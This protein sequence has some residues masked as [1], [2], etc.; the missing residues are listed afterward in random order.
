MTPKPNFTP[1]AQQ[2]IS[3]AKRVAKKFQ[4]NLISVE[5][6]FYAIVNL[7]AGILNE[8]LFI[9][10]I[11]PEELKLEIEKSL[12]PNTTDQYPQDEDE[13][14]YD[15]HFHLILKVSVSISSKL[16]HEYVGIEHILLSLL[17]YEYS[18]IPD[19]FMKFNASED[20]IISEVREYLHIS[21]D[22]AKPQIPKIKFTTKTPIQKKDSKCPNLEKFASNLMELCK[23]KKIDEVIGKQREIE[24]VCEILCRRT[25]NNPV[26]LGDPGVGKTAI[27]EGLSMKIHNGDCPDFLIGK[28][29]YSLDL[30]SLI[31]GT[32]YRGQFE[33]RLKG[34]IEEVKKHPEII[35]FIDEIHTMVGAGAAEGAMDAANL[36][37]PLLARGDLKCIG[38]TTQEEYKKTILKDG[39]LDR[40]FQ[41]VKVSEPSK[42][43]AVQILMGIK[44]KYEKFH[45]ITYS[46][47]IINTIVNLADKYIPSK[48]F[49][50]KAIDILDQVGA[51]VKIK[52]I[53]RP[54]EARDIEDRLEQLAEKEFNLESLG[55]SIDQI[56]EEQIALLEQYDKIIEA[57]A[58]KTIKKKFAAKDKDVH[59]VVSARTGIP[60]KEIAQS[61]GQKILNLATNLNKKIIG[62]K[63]AINEIC[64]SII[65]SRS[66]L[67]EKNKPVGSFLL[68]GAS[69]TG[70]TLTA[71]Y[72]AE[73]IFG[74]PGCLIQLDMSE[75]SEK[76][77]SSRLNGAS[78]GY[79]GYEEGGELTEKVR[80][81]PYSVILFDEIEKAHPDV[82]NILLQIMEEGCLTDNSGRQVSFTNTIIIMTGNVGAEEIAKPNIGFGPS[83]SESESADK[84]KKSLKKVFKP[85]FLNRLNEVIKFNDFSDKDFLKITKL[86]LNKINNKLSDQ[87]I[88]V[89]FSPAV[90]S[91]ISN[92]AQSENLGA[93]PIKRIIQDVIENKLSEFLLINKPK[94][95]SKISFGISK[96]Q[97]ICKLKA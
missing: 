59:L 51:K 65:R 48:K 90:S 40:R 3:E 75:Y 63:H 22:M 50:D 42:E 92:Q 11:N 66:G 93:R 45:S 95:G 76:I 86:E 47:D 27:T 43:E 4:N 91:R 30:G 44:N 53:K 29:I 37:K 6:L 84:L 25:K 15:E 70:K 80:K 21:K 81:N 35:L 57:W 12:S 8:I 7:N 13:P 87:Q 39:A 71:K 19:F 73:F 33:E 68:V 60:I 14:T 1:R 9:L 38:A 31:A 61:E 94:P 28:V 97:I 17:K 67:K 74:D 32:K 85:E 52:N 96:D 62:Q 58:N 18:A 2:A 79:V 23:Q 24:E 5:H 56:E 77:S 10:N 16:S 54:Q 83:H 64:Q 78:P 46:E 88:T 72:I 41:P 49:P 36:L 82:L 34:I 69:G 20:D 26:L 55:Y 89:T